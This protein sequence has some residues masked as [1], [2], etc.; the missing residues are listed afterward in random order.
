M[1][2]LGRTFDNPSLAIRIRDFAYKAEA[3]REISPFLSLP[4]EIRDKIY[5]YYFWNDSNDNEYEPE[6]ARMWP[7]YAKKPWRNASLLVTCKLVAEE[8]RT[9][10]YQ[11]THF[12]FNALECLVL[13]AT[14]DPTAGMRFWFGQIGRTN[15]MKIRS[16]TIVA[17]GY[18]PSDAHPC[19]A[20]GACARIMLV[21]HTFMGSS[22]MQTI[23]LRLSLDSLVV[24]GPKT[25]SQDIC[26]TI[27]Y[28]RVFEILFDG[29]GPNNIDECLRSF[30]NLK[31][32]HI[33]YKTFRS[34]MKGWKISQQAAIYQDF[35]MILDVE[36]QVLELLQALLKDIGK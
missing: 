5:G 12:V 16:M 34:A 22:Q 4:K 13:S 30:P 27:W 31:W 24:A 25:R 9:I 23:K 33:P 26:N 19:V 21:L 10:L 17:K 7:R 18:D 15:L 29:I 8:G 36:D 35:L 3:N 2:Q 20:E 32:L 14:G 6:R 11:D 1:S 28:A